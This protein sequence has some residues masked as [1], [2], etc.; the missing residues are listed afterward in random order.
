MSEKQADMGAEQETLRVET[1]TVRSGLAFREY[2]Q[3]Y[4]LSLLDV[5]LVARVR[6]VTVWKIGVRHEVTYVAV[7]THERRVLPGVLPPV[8]CQAESSAPGTM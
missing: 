1:A 6:Y 2:V 3:H 7:R 4:H 5:A 8:P